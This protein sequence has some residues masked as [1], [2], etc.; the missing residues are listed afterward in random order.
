ML[1]AYLPA[2]STSLAAARACRPALLVI[3]ILVVIMAEPD[4]LSLSVVAVCPCRMLAFRRLGEFLVTYLYVGDPA[5][6]VLL[7]LFA[8]IY[9]AVLSS[10][11]TNG[12]NDIAAI[13]AF[14]ARQPA[15][16][17]ALVVLVHRIHVGLRLQVV[18]H[19]PVTARLASQVRDPI[20]V[21]Q[22]AR[23]IDHVGVRR[24]P[25]LEAEGLE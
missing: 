23:V 17:I 15:F 2:T 8:E 4:V 13:V 10:R 19:L 9:G 22:A 11:A 6:E 1:Q 21:R 3:V 16:Q 12:H 20:G 24:D 18:D 7:Q 25:V 5:G 14:E